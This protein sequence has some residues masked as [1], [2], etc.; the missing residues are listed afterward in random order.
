MEGWLVASKGWGRCP[1]SGG[2]PGAVAVTG[3]AVGRCR[4]RGRPAVSTGLRVHVTERAGARLVDAID[5]DLATCRRVQVQARVF[6]PCFIQ[7]AA[8]QLRRHGVARSFER[9]CGTGDQAVGVAGVHH[10]RGARHVGRAH[11]SDVAEPVVKGGASV[12]DPDGPAP[13][14]LEDER[15][16]HG[17]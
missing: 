8:L 1:G 13:H 14:Q 5:A 7:A 3:R 12:E 11:G 15:L 9:L 6:I 4:W 10:E 2:A 16:V 17:K